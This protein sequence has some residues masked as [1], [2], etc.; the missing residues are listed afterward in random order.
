MSEYSTLRFETAPNTTVDPF[1]ILSL[2][3][4][5]FGKPIVALSR[6]IGI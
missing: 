1:M 3:C 5:K 6:R 2:N 4:C